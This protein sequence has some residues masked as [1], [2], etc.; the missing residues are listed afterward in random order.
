MKHSR[1][2]NLPT[3]SQLQRLMQVQF[4]LGGCRQ[5]SAIQLS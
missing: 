5:T 3:T 2:L 4:Q 1:V